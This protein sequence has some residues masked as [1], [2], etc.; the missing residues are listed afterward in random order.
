MSEANDLFANGNSGFP[1]PQQNPPN[2]GNNYAPLPPNGYNQPPMNQGFNA[3][4][5][6]MVETPTL[7]STLMIPEYDII[8]FL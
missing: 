1:M 3:P 8:K 2:P 7:L 6:P 5:T 4:Q